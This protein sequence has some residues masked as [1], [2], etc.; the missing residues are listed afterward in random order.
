MTHI[1][2]VPR[3]PC[4]TDIAEKG[5]SKPA[6]KSFTP[7][8]ARK[9]ALIVRRLSWSSNRR[10]R[11]N[12]Q[13]RLGRRSSALPTALVVVG[14]LFCGRGSRGGSRSGGLHTGFVADGRLGGRRG[15]LGG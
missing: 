3:E 2:C 1:R 15:R 11:A 7:K 14:L 4:S 6:T 10:E 12:L 8:C 13:Q 9:V 5:H